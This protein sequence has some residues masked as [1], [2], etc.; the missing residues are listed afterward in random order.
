MSTAGTSQWPQKPHWKKMY[1]NLSLKKTGGFAAPAPVLRNKTSWFLFKTSL[2]SGQAPP[3][4]L[5]QAGTPAR[6]R[7]FYEIRQVGTCPKGNYLFRG[8]PGCPS[9]F[10]DKF[11][12]R[13]GRPS[14]FKTGWFLF[15]TSWQVRMP[16]QFY[17]IRQVLPKPQFF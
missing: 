6:P 7:Q 8:L 3:V 17:E 2:H 9:F 15:K 13:A 14:F 10:Q 12:P 5:R 4:F 1:S 11:G 16:L